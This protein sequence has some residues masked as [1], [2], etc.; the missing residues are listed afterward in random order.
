MLLQLHNH[1]VSNGRITVNNKFG[2]MC[3]MGIIRCL[4]R[5]FMEKIRKITVQIPILGAK[6]KTWDLPN[7]KHIVLPLKFSTTTGAIQ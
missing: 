3:R 1:V 4:S 2:R 6:N 7:T 5:T